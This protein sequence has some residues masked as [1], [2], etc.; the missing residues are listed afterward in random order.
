MRHIPQ[1]AQRLGQGGVA[2]VVPVKA[3]EPV[4]P[5]VQ[6]RPEAFEQ[7]PFGCGLVYRHDSPRSLIEPCGSRPPS[8]SSRHQQRPRPTAPATPTPQPPPHQP[9]PPNNHAASATSAS[10]TATD[11]AR[12]TYCASTSTSPLASCPHSET[13]PQT[14]QLPVG[15]NPPGPQSSTPQ[16]DGQG[17]RGP[18]PSTRTSLPAR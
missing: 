12:S 18:S 16:T 4:V 5:V 2:L 14:A 8:A 15:T 9:C 11:D 17:R 1:I 3:F 6:L 13:H 10:P 7:F